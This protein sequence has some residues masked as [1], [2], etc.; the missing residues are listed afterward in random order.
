MP[1]VMIAS[2]T[3]VTVK[4]I[5][6]RSVAKSR[7]RG[8]RSSKPPTSTSATPAPRTTAPSDVVP[9]PP[10]R[11]AG[12]ADDRRDGGG[13]QRGVREGAD[14]RD[15]RVELVDEHGAGEEHA[16]KGEER[17]RMKRPAEAVGVER[18][19]LERDDRKPRDRQP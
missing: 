6:H 4:P 16:G 5:P 14:P 8:S 7:S 1:P 3:A 15:A 13:D 19:R 18:P 10:R 9:S 11:D 12:P 2:P 17:I